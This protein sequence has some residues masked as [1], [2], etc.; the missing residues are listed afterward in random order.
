MQAVKDRG[1]VRRGEILGHEK[2]LF[3][4]PNRWSRVLPSQVRVF[5]HDQQA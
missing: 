3:I 2:Q 4:A 5:R 1:R